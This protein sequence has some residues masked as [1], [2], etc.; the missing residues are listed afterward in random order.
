MQFNFFRIFVAC[1][2][3]SFLSICFIVM[4]DIEVYAQRAFECSKKVD[5]KE[6]QALI[7]NV[8]K[9]YNAIKQL[10]AE[11]LQY[12]YLAAVDTS[13]N[14]RGKVWL[15]KP[16]K[17]K[18][19]YLEPEEQSFLMN[20]KTLWYYQPLDEQVLIQN[21]EDVVLTD[22]PVAFLIGIGDL[23]KD[24]ILQEAC[25]TSNGVVLKLKMVTKP[26]EELEGFSLLIDPLLEFPIGAEIVHVGG[27]KTSIL[28]ENIDFKSAIESLVFKADFPKGTDIND[29]RKG[30]AE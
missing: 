5:N 27:N 24:F 10:Q 22:L 11:F 26:K 6:A 30:K 14:S 1:L 12:S 2:Q 29:M 18:W 13:E 15:E 9:K 21:F 20:G 16:D 7:G 28:L 4:A 17:M 23:R 19:Q 25:R 8:Q 3:I